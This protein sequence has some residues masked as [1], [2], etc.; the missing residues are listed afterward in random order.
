MTRKSNAP[1]VVITTVNYAQSVTGAS[2]FIKEE[3]EKKEKNV[4]GRP[5][6]EPTTTLT[7][8]LPMRIMEVIKIRARLAHM[9]PGVWLVERIIKTHEEK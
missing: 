8:R 1:C 9:S 3:L 5:K 2:V 4:G 7:L 6:R